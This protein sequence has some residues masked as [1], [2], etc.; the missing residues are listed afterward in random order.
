M[1]WVLKTSKQKNRLNEMA[2]HSKD[3][4]ENIHNFTLEN[5]V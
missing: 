2:A 1:F 3:R 4:Y 5:S